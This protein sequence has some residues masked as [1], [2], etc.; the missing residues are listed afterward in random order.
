MALLVVGDWGTGGSLQRTVAAG[1]DSVAQQHP[2]TAIIS[3]GDN[4]YPDGVASKHDPQWKRKFESVYNHKSLLVPW[5][6]VLGNHD[7]RLDPDAQVAY[8]QVNPR[9]NM[10]GRTWSTR[11]SAQQPGGEPVTVAVVGLDTQALTQNVNVEQQCQWL[12][13]T[14]NKCTERWK[15]V[16]GHHP[17]RSYGHYK[18]TAILVRKIAPL[19]QEFGVHVYACGHDHDVQIIKHPNDSFVCL[20]SGGGG[21]SRDTEWGKHTLYA[22]TNGGFAS[23]LCNNSTLEMVVYGSNGEVCAQHV[24]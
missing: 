11:L 15:I 6:A 7:Y 2:L 5:W 10:P 18:D 9:W 19:L 24:L 23:M 12:R 22:G 21:G 3:T 4:I 17:L 13:D 16:V 20:V 8:H 14:L 1:M